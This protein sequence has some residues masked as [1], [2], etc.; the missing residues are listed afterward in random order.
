MAGIIFNSGENIYLKFRKIIWNDPVI[1]GTAGTNV[2]AVPMGINS[3]EELS[4]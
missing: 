1:N 4:F 3:G 2:P